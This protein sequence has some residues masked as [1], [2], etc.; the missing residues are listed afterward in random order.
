MRTFLAVLLSPTVACTGSEPSTEVPDWLPGVDLAELDLYQKYGSYRV[1]TT[2]DRMELRLQKAGWVRQHVSFDEVRPEGFVNRWRLDE[3]HWMDLTTSGEESE[4]MQLEWGPDGRE[5]PDHPHPP[6]SRLTGD[7]A[8]LLAS[9]AQCTSGDERIDF[10][11]D[12]AFTWGHPD[13]VA[14]GR[15]TLAGRDIRFEGARK[16]PDGAETPFR[17]T[18]SDLSIWG[19]KAPEVL[20]C[21]GAGP[22]WTCS[23]TAGPLVWV[24]DGGAGDA[25]TNSVVR[26]LHRDDFPLGGN[27]S[28]IP[29]GTQTRSR[30]YKAAEATNPRDRVEVLFRSAAD[31]DQAE[32]YAYR[33]NRDLDLSGVVVNTWDDAPAPFVVVVGGTVNLGKT[34]P[35][36]RAELEEA[37]EAVRTEKHLAT[38]TIDV[39]DNAPIPDP[40]LFVVRDGE[41]D[42]SWGLMS[43][44]H[45]YQEFARSSKCPDDLVIS[46][47]SVFAR[48]GDDFVER[49]WR[50]DG[51][52]FPLEPAGPRCRVP[53]LTNRY[54]ERQVCVELL[55]SD[56]WI[57]NGKPVDATADIGTEG[58]PGFA[59]IYDRVKGQWEEAHAVP[60]RF[61]HAEA[62][63]LDVVK[64]LLDTKSPTFRLADHTGDRLPHG[65]LLLVTTSDATGA[66]TRVLRGDKELLR[67]GDTT[68]VW[69]PDSGIPPIRD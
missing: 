34:S 32:R 53:Y 64:P 14:T 26:A 24:M 45:Q 69:I 47:H 25:N 55:E 56:E 51:R 58:T 46:Y 2:A 33:L 20:Q 8:A 22:I 67:L 59:V 9:A 4:L 39:F 13:G 36:E 35:E 54:W 49:G 3:E 31:R 17:A 44:T 6:G 52:L 61:D 60:S 68:A 38:L 28:H 12:G 21:G 19:R 23:V 41:D 1:R 57:R 50:V 27:A 29:P 18:C 37:R 42:C 30:V 65:D 5:I 62:P 48:F 15:W 63:G 43:L 16:A 7:T 66:W 11:D 10:S 40:A